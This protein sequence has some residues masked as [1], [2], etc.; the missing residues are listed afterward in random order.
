MYNPD[1][2][3]LCGL[4]EVLGPFDDPHVLFDEAVVLEF[5]LPEH[6]AVGLRVC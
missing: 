6:L 4:D 3:L 2:I 1:D 5:E